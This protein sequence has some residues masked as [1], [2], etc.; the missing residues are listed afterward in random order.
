VLHAGSG[1]L[2]IEDFSA[3]KGDILTIDQSLQGAETVGS[4]GHGGLLL[5]FGTA[6]G[7]I[8]LKNTTSLPAGATHFT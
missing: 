6:S 8:D 4:D 2:T 7:W 3:A 1:N 5:R